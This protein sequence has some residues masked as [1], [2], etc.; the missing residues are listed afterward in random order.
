MLALHPRPR[1]TQGWT[2]QTHSPDDGRHHSVLTSK[3][4]GDDAITEHR[5]GV[6]D[7]QSVPE[8]YGY[9]GLMRSDLPINSHKGCKH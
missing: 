1:Y 9:M 8:G 6:H 2:S 7:L 4:K 5:K 3:G